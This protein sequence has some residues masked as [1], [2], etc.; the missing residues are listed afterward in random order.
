LSANFVDKKSRNKRKMTQPTR[1]ERV[2]FAFGRQ[3]SIQLSYWSVLGR[4]A[5]VG[6]PGKGPIFDL[7]NLLFRVNLGM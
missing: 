7:I 1:F 5:A 6:I 4:L 3:H 2:A